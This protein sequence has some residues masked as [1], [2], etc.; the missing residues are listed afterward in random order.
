MD[1]DTEIVRS[2]RP[3]WK[4]WL[5]KSG[6]YVFG[7]GAYTLLR[8]IQKTG[9]LSEGARLA[10]MSYRYAWGVIRKIEKQL[11]VKLIETHRGGAVGGGGATVT[12]AAL[13]LMSVFSKISDEFERIA[14]RTSSHG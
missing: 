2:L 4:L 13:E 8:A 5:E 3:R 11:G 7:P 12:E 1:R 10:G 9:S 6:V 14:A